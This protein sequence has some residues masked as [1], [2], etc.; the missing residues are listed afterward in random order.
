MN[1]NFDINL[2]FELK[3]NEFPASNEYFIKL[4]DLMKTKDPIA[5]RATEVT[6]DN[7]SLVSKDGRE[8]G[9]ET[10]KELRSKSSK[11]LSFSTVSFCRNEIVFEKR[12]FMVF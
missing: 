11:C 12:F 9:R 6:F 7:L 4:T 2:F 1:H 5:N 10:S 3:K 8:T